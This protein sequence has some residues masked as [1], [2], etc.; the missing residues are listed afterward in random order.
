MGRIRF[1]DV[2]DRAWTVSQTLEIQ[3]QPCDTGRGIARDRAD[4]VDCFGIGSLS[5]RVTSL[6]RSHAPAARF[7]NPHDPGEIQT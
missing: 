4:A 1:A 6:R 2:L 3:P 7:L 5:K